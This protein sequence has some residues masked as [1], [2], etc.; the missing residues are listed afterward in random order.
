[1]HS[2]GSHQRKFPCLD[3]RGGRGGETTLA[4][5]LFRDFKNDCPPHYYQTAAGNYGAFQNYPQ[6]R[7]NH[8][9]DNLSS[10]IAVTRAPRT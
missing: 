1:M 5:M 6:L 2:T 4:V 7:P 8:R 3:V 9:S 10:N